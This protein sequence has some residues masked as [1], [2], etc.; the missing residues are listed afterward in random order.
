MLCQLVCTD[1]RYAR[2]NCF[3]IRELQ[4]VLKRKF[5]VDLFNSHDHRTLL[6]TS[7]LGLKFKLNNNENLSLDTPL[8]YGWGL[9]D[10]NNLRLVNFNT[11]SATT[12]TNLTN[13]TDIYFLEFFQGFFKAPSLSIL[14]NLNYFYFKYVITSFF[15]FLTHF[16]F[17]FLT[18]SIFSC[19][20][21]STFTTLFNTFSINF[22]SLNLFSLK[23]TADITTVN[24]SPLTF[25]S[26]DTH[27]NNLELD[28]NFLEKS[29]FQ[30]VTRFYNPLINYDYKTG[31]YL[32]S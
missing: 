14:E 28:Y 1:R 22:L 24:A 31:H 18:H 9:L 8:F 20:F 4:G 6:N 15:S 30:R 10:N 23:Y 19:T 26:K 12:Y 17:S 2:M 16:N 7:M 3:N 5:F 25:T 21:G 29:D 11:Y 27:T 32:G 13:P